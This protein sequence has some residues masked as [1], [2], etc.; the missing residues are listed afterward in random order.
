MVRH[1][2]RET[3]MK[4]NIRKFLNQKVEVCIDRELG[5]K[6]PKWGFIYLLNYGYVPNTV[7]TDGEEIDCYVLGVYEPIKQFSGKCIAIIHRLNDDD[8]KLIIVPGD[9]KYSDDA[10]I[11][12]T[13]FQERYFDIDI[14]R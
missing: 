3:Y 11:A 13:E 12:L 14:V 9:K 5:S 7:N 8:D 1:E 4:E 6:H 10:I 2:I